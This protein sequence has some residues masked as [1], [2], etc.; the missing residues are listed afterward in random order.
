MNDN[1]DPTPVAQTTGQLM[2]KC[3]T[4][5]PNPAADGTH[6]VHRL[7]CRT[8][9]TGRLG[10]RTYIRELPPL[11]RE[12]ADASSL[13]DEASATPCEAL[14]AALGS[15]LAIGIHANAVAR[16]IPIRHLDIEIAG[17]LGLAAQWG[18]GNLTPKPLGFETITVRV[19]IEAD[20]PREML[21]ALVEHTA[22]WSPVANTLHNPVHLDVVVEKR[23]A[24]RPSEARA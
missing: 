9:A 16:A 15:C 1:S 7:R 5:V 18:T 21:E 19:H 14:L 12:A 22:M 6:N 8:V 11:G 3:E 23:V 4:K 20:V 24:R 13:T 2:G 10:H 17:E